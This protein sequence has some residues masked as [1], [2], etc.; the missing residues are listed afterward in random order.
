MIS[1]D[2][3]H[4]PGPFYYW[5][6]SLPLKST[7]VHIFY[8]HH[9]WCYFYKS[10]FDRLMFYLRPKR[11]NHLP[12]FVSC[13]LVIYSKCEKL[14]YEATNTEWNAAYNSRSRRRHHIEDKPGKAPL[15]CEYLLFR[16]HRSFVREPK[17]C[18]SQSL[19]ELLYRR[20]MLA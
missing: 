8:S 3:E 10:R 7:S 15:H 2:D 1:S 18:G 9:W 13:H 19:Q 17:V 16:T 11:G 20:S 5:I 14:Q 6:S 4:G 12:L